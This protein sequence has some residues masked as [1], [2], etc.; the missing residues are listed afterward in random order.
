MAKAVQKRTLETHARLIA[1]AEEIIAER[2]FEALR[3]DEVVS[4]AGTAKGTFFAHFNDK[5]ALMELIIGGRIDGYLD[6]LEDAQ[7]PSTVAALV[8]ALMPLAMF[9]TCERYVFDLILRYSGAAAVA[10]IGPI[11]ATFSRQI[12]VFERWLATAA[13]RRDI[14]MDLQAEGVQAFLIQ[15]MATQ[16]CALHNAQSIRDRLVPYLAAW[17]T[18][19]A[20]RA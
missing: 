18:P 4:R 2:G 15:A 19:S 9:M 6:A 7:A 5:D 11:A 16:F 13:F 10:E 8:A 14:P 20:G 3:V 1:A 12:D 17:L